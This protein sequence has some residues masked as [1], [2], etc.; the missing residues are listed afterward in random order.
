MIDKKREIEKLA[1]IQKQLL[2]SA[3]THEASCDIVIKIR[4]GVIVWAEST[5]FEKLRIDFK[6]ICIIN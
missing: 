1:Q 3:Q 2:E 4:N 5:P 6:E